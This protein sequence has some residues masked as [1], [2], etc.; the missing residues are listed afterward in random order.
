MRRRRVRLLIAFAFA[1]LLD[2]TPFSVEAQQAPTH[3]P[4]RVLVLYQQ[5]A[6]TRA[7][8]EL[9]RS[10]RATLAEEMG[11]RVEFYQ[12]ALD[13]DRFA[14]R[15]RSSPLVNYFV[16]KYRGFPIDVVVPVG[17][18]ALRFTI[19]E[20]RPMLPRAPIVF[21]LNAAPQTDP[22]TLPPNVTGRL[23]AAS[24][25]APTLEMARRLQPDAER[26]VVI[27]G[28]GPEDSA[29]LGAAVSAARSLRDTLPVE[30]IQGLTLEQLLRRVRTVQ[31]RS[32]VVFANYRQDG[33]GGVFEPLDIIG[34]IARATPA[35]LYTQIHTYIGEGVVG[36][37][38]M[39]FGDEGVRTGRLVARALRRRAGDALP[40]VERIEKHFVADWR[41]LRRWGL[42][43]HRL[44][45]GTEVAFR[46]PS[47]WE[48]HGTV[49]VITMA[50]VAA[51]SLL[52]WLLLLERR[53]RISAQ[54]A[55]EQ[56]QRSAAEVHR[57]LMHMG[58][59]ALVGELTATISHELR[60]PL[61]A[62][63]ANA[64]AGAVLARRGA[65]PEELR[66]VFAAIVEDDQRAVEVVQSVRRLLRKD[67]TFAVKRVDLNEV[68]R[69][70]IPLLQ[71]DAKRRGTRMDLSLT[72]TPAAVM[73]DPVQLQQVVI[74]L[75]L[76]AID[77]A[78]MSIGERFVGVETAVAGNAVELAVRDSGPGIPPEV[79]GH[80]FES[81]FST[82]TGGL[83]L[84]LVIVR[85]IVERH[86][87]R[88]SVENH[89]S[90]GAVFRVRLPMATDK[91]V[92]VVSGNGSSRQPGKFTGS[93]GRR[94]EH[95]V[96]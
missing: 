81:F 11:G 14:G 63:R 39:R 87:G 62:I 44:P 60:Q 72:A 91:S 40:P 61:A 64:E 80:L 85:S 88:V 49:V 52:I 21:A 79:E 53:R 16:D 45:R 42:P 9:A 43:E 65:P 90:G 12:E 68:C 7:M 8:E 19:D 89:A 47:A 76:N 96:T 55:M 6:E 27:G 36:G 24:R 13:L 67:E 28:A 73:G 30:V 29:S 31:P 18:R 26:I 70:A 50:V 51:E 59:V 75:I 5:R 1:S 84:G 38:V 93:A 82:K 66:E 23:A 48:Q 78:A 57:Q 37:S 3:G 4:T 56:E 10:L 71:H 69:E 54:A 74:N 95:I 92:E 41:Q 25:F 58:R 86:S 34:T 83:G 94:T 35:P 2:S 15:E 20:L 22:S 33:Q 17:G 46:E 77:A 32:I